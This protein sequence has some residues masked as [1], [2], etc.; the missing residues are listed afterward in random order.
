MTKYEALSPYEKWMVR[1]NLQT[2]REH[3][4]P[5]AHQA[6]IVRANGYPQIADAI[7][8]FSPDL[9]T[10]LRDGA[11]TPEQLEIL[12][13]NGFAQAVDIMTTLAPGSRSLGTGTEQQT[14]QNTD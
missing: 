3:G 13:A 1:S 14:P 4:I 11:P 5:A 9:Q 8:E 10:I 7:L 12:R 2:I 6:A